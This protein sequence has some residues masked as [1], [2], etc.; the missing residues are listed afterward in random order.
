MKTFYAWIEDRQ[1]LRATRKKV[2]ISLTPRDDSKAVYTR[3]EFTTLELGEVGPLM[4]AITGVIRD[5]PTVF[6]PD[7]VLRPVMAETT[8]TIRHNLNEPL[9]LPEG[10]SVIRRETKVDDEP[11]L[12]I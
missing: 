12:V 2:V 3:R 8:V 7:G 4:V 1:G 11:Y 5:N 10:Y 9:V 6:Y